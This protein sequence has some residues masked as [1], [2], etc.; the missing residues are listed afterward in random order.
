M[1]EVTFT[2][3]YK[4]PN[5]S[6]NPDLSD[7]TM[8]NWTYTGPEILYVVVDETTGKVNGG[9]WNTGPEVNAPPGN[10]IVVVRAEDL[11]E[12]ASLL[13]GCLDDDHIRTI[14]VNT[15]NGQTLQEHEYL[16]LCAA[17]NLNGF[18]YDFASLQWSKEWV[19][20]EHTTWEEIRTKRNFFLEGTD[21]KVRNDMPNNVRQA[22]TAYRT[23]LRDITTN[24][25]GYEPWQV[26]FPVA[27]DI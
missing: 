9:M 3:I 23:L 11:P 17:Y 13:V 25:A 6:G 14:S 8:Q 5:G 15:P 24:W 26:E 12:L 19:G 1:T 18:T 4:A 22:W 21:S 20:A 10:R 16:P 2:F 27:P 7:Y